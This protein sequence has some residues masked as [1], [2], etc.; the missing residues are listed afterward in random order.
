MCVVVIVVVLRVVNVIR[1]VD[2]RN[3]V[4]VQIFVIVRHIERSFRMT[5]QSIPRSAPICYRKNNE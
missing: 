5:P 3:V 1:V 2:V 4:F